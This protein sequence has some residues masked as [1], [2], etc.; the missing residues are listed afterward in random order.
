MLERERTVRSVGID[1]SAKG[2]EGLVHLMVI[3]DHHFQAEA[4]CKGDLLVVGYAAVHGDDQPRA[5]PGDALY[6]FDMESVS[7]GQPI[8]DIG[9]HRDAEGRKEVE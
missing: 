9:V 8:G 7:F 5:A 1:N 2:S 4:C 3:R 6:R